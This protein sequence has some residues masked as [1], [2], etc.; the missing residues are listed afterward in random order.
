MFLHLKLLNALRSLHGQPQPVV[1]PPRL[2]TSKISLPAGDWQLL[3]SLAKR[4]NFNFAYFLTVLPFQLLELFR[5]PFPLSLT[6]FF[7]RYCA[8]YYLFPVIHCLP[9]LLSPKRADIN[10]SIFTTA[11]DVCFIKLNDLTPDTLYRVRVQAISRV[12]EGPHSS[13]V[14]FRTQHDAPAAPRLEA[15]PGNGFVKLSWTS[16]KGLETA[17]M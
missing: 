8:F 10:G 12:G 9:S 16:T 4:N 7:N 14:N 15:N 13:L 1:A 11:D 2:G 6:L 17:Y 3:L 5:Q